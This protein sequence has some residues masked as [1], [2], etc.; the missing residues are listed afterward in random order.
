VFDPAPSGTV[1]AK[2]GRGMAMVFLHLLI[3]LILAFAMPDFLVHELSAIA[4]ALQ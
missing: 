1:P 2:A 4:G 3:I